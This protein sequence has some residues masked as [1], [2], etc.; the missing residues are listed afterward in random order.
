MSADDEGPSHNMALLH[1][2]VGIL[3][4]ADPEVS[5]RNVSARSPHRRVTRRSNTL[6]P[7]LAPSACFVA[8]GHPPQQ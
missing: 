2:D 4:H 3:L 6:T 7:S 8:R 1:E 5:D